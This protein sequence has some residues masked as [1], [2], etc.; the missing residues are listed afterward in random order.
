MET[1]G[2]RDV[3]CMTQREFN[4]PVIHSDSLTATQASPP[5][6]IWEEHV[7]LAQLR[8]A[9]PIGYK[10]TPH[11]HPKAAL[12]PRR[13]PTPSNT[14]IPRPTPLTIPNDF[15]IQLAVL[16]QYTFRTDRHQT[17]WWDKR[18]VYS[19]SAY[20]VLIVSDA[21]TTVHAGVMESWQTLHCSLLVSLFS[22][23]FST[24]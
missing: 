17:D 5:R 9:V 16:P 19:N 6:V 15:R 7:A 14:P 10:G 3:R 18:Q 21:L 13:S 2:A 20:A 24:F 8:N 22:V 23:L 1:K 11:I 4:W 12:S